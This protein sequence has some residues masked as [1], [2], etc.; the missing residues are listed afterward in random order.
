MIS[1]LT[2][3]SIIKQY[4]PGIYFIGIATWIG[5]VDA[6]LW[7]GLVIALFIIQ[8]LFNNRYINLIL[9]FLTILWSLYMLVA[10]FYKMDT[11]INFMSVTLVLTVLNFYMSRMLFLNQNFSLSSLRENSLDEILFL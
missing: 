1:S 3:P 5:Y 6:N 7:M 8:M 10:L 2:K 4:L 11:T 9:G